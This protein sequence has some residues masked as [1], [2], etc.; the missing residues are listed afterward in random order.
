MLIRLEAC[1][2]TRPLGAFDGPAAN[3][4]PADCCGC[5]EKLKAPSLP[6]ILASLLLPIPPKANGAGEADGVAAAGIPNT[7]FED[8][9]CALNEKFVG[10]TF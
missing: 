6:P 8:D 10:V 7:L 3:K 5:A 1:R 9:C 2:I 4:L